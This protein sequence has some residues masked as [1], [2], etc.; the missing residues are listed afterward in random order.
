MEAALNSVE[1]AYRE[2]NSGRFPRGL[3]AMIQSLSTWLYDN[4]PMAPLAWEAPLDELKARVAAGEP[5]FEDALRRWFLNNNH[6]ATVILLPDATLAATRDAAEQT[7]VDAVQRACDADA[8][9]AMASDADELVFDALP[10]EVPALE[11]LVREVME[12]VI[13]LSVPLTVS[14]AAGANWLEAH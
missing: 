10:D 13:R 1:F 8:R 2:N 9:K 11:A 5:V 3:S 6:R 12:N 7:R 4:D 14:C